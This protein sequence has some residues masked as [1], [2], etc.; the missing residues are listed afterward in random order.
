MRQGP[1]TLLGLVS[2]VVAVVSDVG[3][4]VVAVVAAIVAAV[5]TVGSSR[6]RQKTIE[7]WRNT[8]ENNLVGIGHQMNWSLHISEIGIVANGGTVGKELDSMVLTVGT[9]DNLF[10][11]FQ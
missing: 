11:C 7:A 4:I 8:A 5:A 9:L 1:A 2:I 6:R 3:N 10:E